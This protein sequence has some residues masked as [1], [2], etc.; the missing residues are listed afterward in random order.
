MDSSKAEELKIKVVY[1]KD[2][3]RWHYPE[4]DRFTSL[5]SF[6]EKT[7]QLKEFQVQYE[8]S[9][10]DRITLTD[11]Q[12]FEDAFGCALSQDRK[13]LKLFV[14]T[15]P[16]Q[17]SKKKKVNQNDNKVEEES[18]EATNQDNSSK[19]K[20]GLDFL[21]DENV[22]RLLPELVQTVMRALRET[23][24]VQV[25]LVEVVQ[26]VLQEE[27]FAPI[28]CHE[29]YQTTIQKQLPVWLAQIAP[30]T[31][32]LLNFGEEKV[33]GIISNALNS[34][35]TT[36]AAEKSGQG[37]EQMWNLSP[38]NF[39]NFL[40]R[41]EYTGEGTIHE[42]VSCD[43]CKMSPIQG[44]RYKCTVC[45][46]FDLCGTCEAAKIHDSSHPLLKMTTGDRKSVV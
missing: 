42:G 12:D 41:T 37:N 29:F 43:G 7:F 14:N 44:T 26:S 5:L 6:V 34:M 31:G 1:G 17:E 20:L 22:K 18:N 24:T 19:H 30:F 32:L 46:N 28:V 38:L 3:R 15:A 16:Q 8:D 27:K 9:E 33:I 39:L 2:I 36:L 35:T 11:E 10:N 40:P 4:A 13:S 21:L 25:S 45:P 23:G